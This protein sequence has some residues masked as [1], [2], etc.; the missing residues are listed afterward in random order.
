MRR[1]I[2]I[3]TI[4]SF[5]FLHYV[6]ASPQERVAKHNLVQHQKLQRKA[7]YVESLPRLSKLA[8][9]AGPQFLTK[10][11]ERFAV[12]GASLLNV[13]FDIGESYAGLL[14]VDNTGKELFFWFVPSTN[15]AAHDEIVIWLNGGPGCSSL[16]GFFKEN[17]PVTWMSGTFLPVRNQ[18]SWTNLSNV[19]WIDQPVGTGF[20]QGIPNATSEVDVANQFLPFWKNFMNTFDLNHK[21]VYITGES[22]AGVIATLLRFMH[23]GLTHSADVCAIYCRCDDPPERFRAL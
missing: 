4:L 7:D 22:Y 17:G 14:P 15:P 23:T 10:K 12:D 5:V 18:Y 9:R 19:V 21:K 8:P 3:I 16:D 20:T 2:S 6:F 13:S 1:T 11:T